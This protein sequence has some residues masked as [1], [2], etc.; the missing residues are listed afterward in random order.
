[1]DSTGR[2]HTPHSPAPLVVRTD[3]VIVAASSSG[4]GS[5]SARASA[6]GAAVLPWRSGSDAAPATGSTEDADDDD[7]AIE[8]V[9]L[10]T[11]PQSADAKS[12][13]GAGVGSGKGKG[14]SKSKPRSGRS[15]KHGGAGHSEPVDGASPL[16]LDVE[17]ALE[18]GLGQLGGSSADQK[19]SPASDS[20]ERPRAT[21]A[22]M[23]CDKNV[24][25]S[26]SLYGLLGLAAAAFSEVT[27]VW[28]VA[29]L[30]H[31]GIAFKSSDIGMLNLVSGLMLLCSQTMFPWMTRRFGTLTLFRLAC[32]FVTLTT[33]VMALCTHFAYSKVAVW[34][35]M[36]LFFGGS[37]SI[38]GFAFTSTFQLIRY[39]TTPENLGAANG[40]GQS[41]V[42]LARTIG[43]AAGG[44]LLAWSLEGGRTFPLDQ[45][46]AFI[47]SA[48]T[49]L[50][51]FA[52]SFALGP[53][54]NTR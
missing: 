12:G 8:L 54:F 26:S 11:D 4:G 13:K 51:P 18:Q 46:F 50:L 15:L 52:L 28:A 48:L 7:L 47:V 44:V 31:G 41:M 39:C 42:A 32:F 53:E 49:Y 9:P 25:V 2:P 3:G 40:I 38:G 27:P 5:G 43:P 1:M 24:M 30:E 20:G 10:T 36:I 16:S 22:Q 33:S 6:P 45:N 14:K 34:A 29:D 21:F 23:L 19:L 17:D 35:W 37:L